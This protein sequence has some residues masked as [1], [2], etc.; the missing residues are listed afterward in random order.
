MLISNFPRLLALQR[1]IEQRNS[2]FQLVNLATIAETPFCSQTP[3]W[4]IRVITY[5]Y[6]RGYV[7]APVIVCFL[8]KRKT[9][10]RSYL[11]LLIIRLEIYCDNGRRYQNDLVRKSARQNYGRTPL[12]A[13]HAGNIARQIFT[14][15]LF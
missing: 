6:S 12:R 11:A 9:L 2:T 4:V 3:T 7:R 8:K 5:T 1:L 13:I 15:P 10:K 14:C